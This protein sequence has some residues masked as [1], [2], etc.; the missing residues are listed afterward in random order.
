MT[1]IVYRF[2]GSFWIMI[3]VLIGAIALAY[4]ILV[5]R[6]TAT[7]FDVL[8][9]SAPVIDFISQ[10]L[11]GS[12]YLN[13]WGLGLAIFLIVLGAR[14]LA[15]SPIARP[16]AMAFHLLAGLFVLFISL[17]AYLALRGAGGIVIAVAGGA[18]TTVILI[19]LALGVLLLLIGLGRGTR[20]AAEAFAASCGPV[21]AAVD[22]PPPPP[23]LAMARLI[24]RATED[25]YTLRSDI[26][27]IGIGRD[28]GQ[29]IVLNES[30]VSAN[31]ALI[32]VLGSDFLLRDL[33]S[34]NGTRVNGQPLKVIDH[35]LQNN[36]EIEIGRVRL[37][38]ER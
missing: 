21:L 17:V 1:S 34:S 15:L 22:P 36:D 4:M 26:G 5:E 12:S 23:P 13:W 30:S 32:E 29:A 24:N 20:R 6:I 38:F 35:I 25:V 33:G 10:R 8:G 28:A 11:G 31:H 18:G 7:A 37:R 9:G 2:L 27:P 16:V 3:G 14:L 19:G